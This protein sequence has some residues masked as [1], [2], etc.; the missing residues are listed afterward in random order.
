MRSPI[1]GQGNSF[2][3]I[4]AGTRG[5]YALGTRRQKAVNKPNSFVLVVA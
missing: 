3:T 5:M 2:T 1:S 4:R